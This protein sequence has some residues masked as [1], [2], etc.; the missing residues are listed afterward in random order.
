[1]LIKLI[2]LC[3]ENLKEEGGKANFSFL[4]EKI[5]LGLRVLVT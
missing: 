5:L 4:K 2:F 1:M 3:W